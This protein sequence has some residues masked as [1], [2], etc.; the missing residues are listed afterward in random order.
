MV[1]KRYYYYVIWE[2]TRGVKGC[3]N[4]GTLRMANGPGC[5]TFC[6]TVIRRRT[7]LRSF[8]EELNM[9]RKRYS[10]YVILQV[11]CGVKGCTNVGARLGPV[12]D[13]THSASFISWQVEKC[14]C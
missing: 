8:C 3:T 11:A 7:A 5:K 14:K 4:L 1:Q 6:R 12:Y 10:Y 9:V 13:G 2:A